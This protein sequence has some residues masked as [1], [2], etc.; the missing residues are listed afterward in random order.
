MPMRVLTPRSAHGRPSAQPPIDMSGNFPAHVSAELPTTISLDFLE[1]I[2]NV[3]ENSKKF[4]KKIKNLKNV[5]R[6]RCHH[7]RP[8][9][10]RYCHSRCR[11]CTSLRPI[12]KALSAELPLTIS[13]DCLELISKVSENFKNFKKN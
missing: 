7:R 12:D 3:S 9:H 10:H 8:R 13:P 4:L 11:C 6:H 1:L 5:P 2:S